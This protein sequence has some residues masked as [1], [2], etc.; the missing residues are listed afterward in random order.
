[1]DEG[2][3]YAYPNEVGGDGRLRCGLGAMDLKRTVNDS[4]AA[5]AYLRGESRGA[6]QRRIFIRCTASKA[7]AAERNR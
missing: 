2:S 5:A 1:M 4:V 6:E 3:R 7:V